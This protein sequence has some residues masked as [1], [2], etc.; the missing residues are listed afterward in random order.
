M[1]TL[2]NEFVRLEFACQLGGRVM[3][4]QPGEHHFFG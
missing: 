3:S 4:Y 2:S 1:N